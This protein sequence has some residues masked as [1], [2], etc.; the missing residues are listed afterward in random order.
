VH[1]SRKRPLMSEWAKLDHSPHAGSMSGF[2]ES[3]HGSA[4][5]EYTPLTNLMT[6][7]A[8]IAERKYCRPRARRFHLRFARV[9]AVL[10]VCPPA[11]L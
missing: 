6:Q 11:A 9:V 8:Q 4:I 3:G 1:R 7:H 2:A 10:P 5:Y